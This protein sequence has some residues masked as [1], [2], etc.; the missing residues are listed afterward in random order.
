MLFIRA[1]TAA[2]N[3]TL[4]DPR[5]SS[6]ALFTARA[7]IPKKRAA[8]ANAPRLDADASRPGRSLRRTT[9]SKT[10]A[11]RTTAAARPERERRKKAEAAARTP[12]NGKDK[13]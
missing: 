5:R 2:G 3:K 12:Q 4:T 6:H 8:A 11:G 10:K 7:A 9:D 13:A 1:K